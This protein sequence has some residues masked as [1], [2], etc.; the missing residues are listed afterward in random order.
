MAVNAGAVAAPLAFVAAVA[1]ADPPKRALAPVL[2]AVKVTMTPLRRLFAASFTTTCSA[3]PNATL[4]FPLCGVPAVAAILAGAPA[5]FVKLKLADVAT[6][7][8]LAFTRKVPA[9]PLAVSVGAVAIPLALVTA[10]AVADPPNVPEAPV[11]GAVKVTVTPL[12]GALLAFSTVACSA[13]PYAVLTA[14]LCGVPAVAVIA[15][16]LLDE[17]ARESAAPAKLTLPVAVALTQVTVRVWPAEL[18][19]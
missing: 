1:V 12:M 5:R 9:C 6:P 18:A 4:M 11:L 15:A 2:G 13:V 19:L 7:V 10:V 3:V 17:P 8:V 16:G 14:T